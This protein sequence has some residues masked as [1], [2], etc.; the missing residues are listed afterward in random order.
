ME[1]IPRNATNEN[2][3][4][5]IFR[6]ESEEFVEAHR[7]LEKILK[8]PNGQFSFDGREVWIKNVPRS[9]KTSPTTIEITTKKGEVGCVGLQFFSAQKSSMMITKQ[10][11][12]EIIMVKALAFKVIK[13]L[14]TGL[15]SG[16]LNE[17]SIMKLQKKPFDK[18]I[19]KFKPSDCTQ[20][21]KTF[22]NSHGVSVHM[23]KIHEKKCEKCQNT[24]QNTNE[25][26]MHTDVCPLE[27]L[28]SIVKQKRQ[29]EKKGDQPVVTPPRKNLNCDSCNYKANAD[30]ELENHNRREHLLS[31]SPDPKRYK[32]GHVQPVEE[33][34]DRLKSLSV[35]GEEDMDFI[36][37]EVQKKRKRGSTDI[38]IPNIS[39]IS[40]NVTK[41]TMENREKEEIVEKDPNLRD[42]PAEVKEIVGNERKEYMVKGDGPCLLRTTAA[43]TEGDEDKGIEWARNL[44]THEALYRDY[45]NEKLSSNDFPMIVTVGVK[46]ETKTFTNSEDY[47][48]W[49]VQAKEAAFM[50]RGCI[51]VMAISNM[52]QM[53][54]DIIVHENGQ[55][56]QLRSFEPDI[57][58][59]WKDEDPMKPE[60]PERRKQD[61]MM[62]LNWKDVHLILL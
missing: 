34:L 56:A 12:N 50:W 28:K 4:G 58:F 2:K 16:E 48:D 6:G 23:A 52:A 3:T 30:N 10:S 19:G 46:G 35:E 37:T 39:N 54:I 1:L 62:V 8:I 9:T 41:I 29:T 20:C 7:K 14:L 53:N 26:K 15:I 45:Y 5:V 13:P 36:E 22:V 42:L 43:H 40:V 57:K 21:G 60:N 17:E 32:A 44:N 38:T 33:A 31:L 11:N 24:F 55:K 18:T 25:L 49:L 61:K 59:P 51:D 47:F 27:T